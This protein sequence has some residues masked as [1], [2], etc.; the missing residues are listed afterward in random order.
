MMRRSGSR[1]AFTAVS[2]AIAILL[3]QSACGNMERCGP[4]AACACPRTQCTDAALTATQAG[5]TIAFPEGVYIALSLPAP[6][7]S[8]ITSSDTAVV[9]AAEDAGGAKRP[10]VRALSPGTARVTLGPYAYNLRIERW[11]FGLGFPPQVFS[12]YRAQTAAVQ[13]GEEFGIRVSETPAGA[14]AGRATITSLDPA[15]LKPVGTEFGSPL[16]G[17]VDDFEV[18]RAARKGQATISVVWASGAQAT[19]TVEVS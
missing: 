4:G 17:G 7:G 9:D 13:L 19:L 16:R 12:P 6:S 18:F 11:P 1:S 10:V 3:P 15:T 5:S 2:L 14:P 8:T